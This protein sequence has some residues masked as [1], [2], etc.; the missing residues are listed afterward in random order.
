MNKQKRSEKEAALLREKCEKFREATLA[1]CLARSHTA[2]R[3]IEKFDP[4][5]LPCVVFM[6]NDPCSVSVVASTW[7]HKDGVARPTDQSNTKDE[8]SAPKWWKYPHSSCIRYIEADMMAGNPSERALFVEHLAEVCQMPH[9]SQDKHVLLLHN[10]EFLTTRS[11]D[12][13]M[14]S[15][16]GCLIATTSKIGAIS[17]KLRVRALMVRIVCEKPHHKGLESLVDK[18][19]AGTGSIDDVRKFAHESMK[20]CLSTGQIFRTLLDTLG[21]DI[22]L[23]TIETIC[24]LDHLSTRTTICPH[25]IE[26]AALKIHEIQKLNK[27]KKVVKAK[28]K[29]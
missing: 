3:F 8:S 18:M 4:K 29:A 14:H 24:K 16:H 2:R 9:V 26:A 23:E 5:D 21:S 11:M 10:I 17:D 15:R 12:L 6:G 25:A 28:P 1:T 19:L 13:L 27:K 22:S 7:V 20:F